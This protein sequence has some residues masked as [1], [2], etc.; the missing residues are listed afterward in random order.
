MVWGLFPVDPLPG[1]HKYYFINKGTYRVGRKG[2]DIIVNKDKG[3]SRIHAEIM[4]EEMIYLDKLQKLSDVVSKVRIRDCSKYGTFLDNNLTSKVKVHELPNKETILKDGDRVSFGTGSAIYRFSFVPLVFFICSSDNSKASQVITKNLSS[5]GAGVTRKWSSICSHVLVEGSI[6]FKEGLIDAIVA[7][8]PFVKSSWVELVAGNNIVTDIPSYNAHVPTLMLEGAP[9]EVAVPEAREHCL[10]AY[11]FILG[12]TNTYKL[13]DRLQSLLE[14]SG[15][16][17]SSMETFCPNSQVVKEDGNDK[18]IL[19]IPEIST[20]FQCFRDSSLSRVNEM[21]LV[22]AALSGHLDPSL[23]IS[24][25][26][27]VTSS[28]STEETV[29]ADSEAETECS[30]ESVR[31]A[32]PL[33]VLDSDDEGDKETTAIHVIESPENY[34]KDEHSMPFIKPIEDDQKRGTSY[35]TSKSIKDEDSMPFIKPIEDD[36]KRGTSY[37][38]AKSTKHDEDHEI[39]ENNS[40]ADKSGEG[41]SKMS[42][43]KTGSKMSTRLKIDN[44]ESG[45]SDIIFSQDLI[46]RE[47]NLTAKVTSA[48]NVGVANFKRFRKT[49]VPS[50]NSYS[51]LI[52]YAKHPYRESDYNN[53]EVV[54]SI[55][56][57]K[58]RKQTEAR[59]EDLFNEKK[60]KRRGVAGSLLG[61]LTRG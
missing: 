5:I 11:T 28:C 26:V 2:C 3:V 10:K 61:V 45:N 50:G 43:V 19:V 41:C 54:E 4:I 7:R 8:K 52:P 22:A 15:A 13:K 6:A 48:T 49:Q 46:I 18:T 20:N 17:V 60:D 1:E 23:I 39:P 44:S 30:T 53:D 35:V 29:V 31:G 25:P 42:G 33:C 16:K 40:S 34:I 14:V 58:K 12:V 32:V 36:Q 59:A 37:V 56:E 21:D 51:S 27:K 24:P 57:E 38:T 47:C 9:V 55:K